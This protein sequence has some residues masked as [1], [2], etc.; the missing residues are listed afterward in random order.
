MYYTEI[1]KIIEA[2]MRKDPTK[3]ASYSRLLAKKLSGDGEKR[4][5]N[6]ILSVLDKMGK[7]LAVMDALT[8][9][10]VDQESRLGIADID[11]APDV[12]S[13]ILSESVQY[14][15]NDFR[16]TI[17]NKSKMMSLGLEF[18]NT[19]L[20]YGPPGC[21]KTSAAKYL[22]SELELPLVTA[23]FDTLISYL[24]GNTAK[25]IHRIFEFGKKQP[26]VLFFDEF[27]AIAKARDDSHELG[28]LK[29]VVNS[30]LQNIDDFSQDGILI[31]ATNHAQ[32]LDK[33]VW[34]R[35]QTVIELPKPGKDEI[36]RYITQFPKVADES[37]INEPQW[38]TIIDLMSDLSYSDI[39]DVVQ[40]VL[41]KA[42][43]KDKKEIECADYIVEVFLFK[44][45]GNY[46]QEEVVKFL[47]ECGVAQK[48]I[49]RYCSISERQVRNFLGKGVNK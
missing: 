30:L 29:R 3:V 37:R 24:L 18:R 25:N 40:N 44:N 13:L 31:A 26:C 11:Y 27:D 10:P 22:A 28:E 38:R 9:M 21:G 42:V 41:K 48:Q 7:G 19:L 5:S 39:K 2:G 49:A 8:T 20:L 47:Y 16:D 15:L 33:A 4:A 12:D 17:Q 46:N 34:R 45:H 35:F 14:M 43:L 36:R 6:R 1:T 32:M 23:R